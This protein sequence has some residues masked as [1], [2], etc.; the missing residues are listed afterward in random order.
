MLTES[1]AG[2]FTPWISTGVGGK[3]EK[4]QSFSNK[5]DFGANF[6][7][8]TTGNGICMTFYGIFRRRETFFHVGQG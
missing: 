2:I 4:T 7:S 1:E 3:R 8:F 5:E 6:F